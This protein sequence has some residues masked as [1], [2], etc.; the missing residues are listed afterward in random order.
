MKNILQALEKELKSQKKSEKLLLYEYKILNKEN[1]KLQNK[2]SIS[3]TYYQRV[4]KSI[5]IKQP[6][7][8]A[9]AA[10]GA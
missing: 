8:A 4:R 10:M 5:G 9:L 6:L 7:T 3:F 1:K 2:K